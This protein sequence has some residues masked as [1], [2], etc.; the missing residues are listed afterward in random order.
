MLQ[1][2]TH[3]LTSIHAYAHTPLQ[4]GLV[5]AV[6]LQAESFPQRPGGGPSAAPGCC[7]GC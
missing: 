2:R 1:S 6:A 7:R 5:M 3:H 4:Q